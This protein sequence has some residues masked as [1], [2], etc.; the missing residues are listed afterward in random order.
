MDLQ[1]PLF[2]VPQDENKNNKKKE[3]LCTTTDAA[4]QDENKK[5]DDISTS[6]TTI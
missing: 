4:F 2:Y 6:W 5:L 3:R 1:C